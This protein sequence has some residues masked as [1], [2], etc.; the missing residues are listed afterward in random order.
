MKRINNLGDLGVN[1]RLGEMDL[2]EIYFENVNLIQLAQDVN[3]WRALVEKV[4]NL[5]IP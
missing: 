4:I 1:G 2:K 5:W 3:H